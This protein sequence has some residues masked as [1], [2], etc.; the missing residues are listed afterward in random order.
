MTLTFGTLAPI[1]NLGFF[2]MDPNGGR[3]PISIFI[4]GIQ[5]FHLSGA[6]AN[7]KLYYIAVEGKDAINSVTFNINRPNGKGYAYSDGYGLDNVTVASEAPE[8]GTYAML[9]TGLLG[10]VYLRRKK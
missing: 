9:A 10:L 4:M 2:F 5:N 8:P 3:P 6:T 1:Y 7:G